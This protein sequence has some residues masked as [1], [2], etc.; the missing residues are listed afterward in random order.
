[1]G[2]W[3][4]VYCRILPGSEMPDAAVVGICFPL[5]FLFWRGKIPVLGCKEGESAALN[6]TFELQKTPTDVME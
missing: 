1:M 5:F 6:N 3:L 4:G 2:Q